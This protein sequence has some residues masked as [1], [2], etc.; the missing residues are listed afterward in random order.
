MNKIRLYIWNS[1]ASATDKWIPIQGVVQNSLQDEITLDESYDNAT[2]KAINK[3]SSMCDAFSKFYVSVGEFE[4][5]KRYYIGSEKVVRIQMSD[6]YEHTYTLIEP[7]KLLE[8]YKLFGLSVTQPL[9]GTKKTLRDVCNRAFNDVYEKY[10]VSFFV[11][12]N[13][14]LSEVCPEFSVTNKTTLFEFLY[15]NI[16]KKIGAMPRLLGDSSAVYNVITFDSFSNLRL[17]NDIIRTN[18]YEKDIDDT[19]C[20]A[21]FGGL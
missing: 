7:T 17:S 16:G 11:D 14:D 8:R 6:Y 2:L 1:K 13:V 15:N 3:D 4:T 21:V 20:P 18:G 9:T 19:V 12:S 5:E 10:G